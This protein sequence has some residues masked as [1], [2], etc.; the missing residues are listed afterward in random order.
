VQAALQPF[1]VGTV[2]P[3]ETL[4][5]GHSPRSRTNLLHSH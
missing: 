3:S 1:C 5:R 2:D 4:E